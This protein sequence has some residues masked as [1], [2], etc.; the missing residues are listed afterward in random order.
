MTHPDVVYLHPSLSSLCIDKAVPNFTTIMQ[1]SRVQRSVHPATIQSKWRSLRE[2]TLRS[3][4]SPNSTVSCLFQ[5]YLK[6]QARYEIIGF[7]SIFCALSYITEQNEKAALIGVSQSTAT[8]R[9]STA[10]T[11]SQVLSAM[12]HRSTK[13]QSIGVGSL[14]SSQR[15]MSA[16]ERAEELKNK[17]AKANSLSRA[18]KIEAQ[19]AAEN[20][21]KQTVPRAPNFAS[22]SRASKRFLAKV[23]NTPVQP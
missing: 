16:T 11:S 15:P 19:A 17:A 13:G 10:A 9:P 1:V 21:K 8:L 18:M 7:Y 2:T 3:P 6:E 23:A 5:N 14:S 12:Q 22:D 4:S 20:K